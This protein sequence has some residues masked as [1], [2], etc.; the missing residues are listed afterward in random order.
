MNSKNRVILASTILIPVLLYWGFGESPQESQSDSQGLSNKIDYFVENATIREWAID[1]ELKR[2]LIT[3]KLEH[4]PQIEASFLTNPQ[5]VHIKDNGEGL[6]VISNQGIARDDNSQTDLLGNV[7]IYSRKH[8][9]NETTLKTEKL[10]FFPQQDIA[11]TD[12]PV[13]I[14]SRHTRMEGI[15]M[16]IDFNEQVLNLHSQV[17]GTHDNAK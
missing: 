5:V 10:S 15:G 14:E 6:H 12:Q 7:V 3:E 9:E 1:G 16:D 2:Q 13:T 8:Q 4:N 17:E 11:Q